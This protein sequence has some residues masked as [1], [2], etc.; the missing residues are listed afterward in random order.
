VKP[1]IAFISEHASPLAAPG[2]IDSGGQNVYVANVARRLARAGY[3]VDIFTRRS[4]ADQPRVVAW[5]DGVRVV[6][7]SAGPAAYV[8]KE[9]LLPFMDDFRDDVLAFMDRERAPYSIVHAHFWMSALVACELKRLRQIPFVVTFHALGRIRRRFQGDADGFPDERF[10]IED[11]VIAECDRVIAECP[12]ELEDLIVEYRADPAKIAVV[13]CGF[14]GQELWPMPK[15]VARKALGLPRDGRVVLHLGRMVPRKGVDTV[16]RGFARLRKKAGGDLV[17]VVAGGGGETSG[18][19]GAELDRLRDLARECGVDDA[20]QFAGRIDR[21]ML[22]YYYSAADVFV[23]VPWYEPFGITPLEAMACGTPVVGANVGGIKFTVRDAET[24]Y[25]VPPRDEAALADRLG[26]LFAHPELLHSFGRQG[27]RRVHALFTWDQVTAGLLATYEE[28]LA[29]ERSGGHERHA[30]VAVVDDAF[31]AATEAMEASR[32]ALRGGVLDAVDII[33]ACFTRGGKVLVAGN[34][35][36]AAEA[37]HFAAE[38]V[39]RF[40]AERRGLPVVS[41]NSDTAILTAWSNDY[42][43]ESVFARQVAALGSPGDVFIGFSTSGRSPN[44]VQAFEEAR[45]RGIRTIALLGGTGG[46][47]AGLADAALVVPSGDTQRIQE[48]HAV[49]V[50]VLSALVERR[51]ACPGTEPSSQK[52]RRSQTRRR[53]SEPRTP[54]ARGLTKESI[55]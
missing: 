13:P 32:V 31:A 39:G 17:L 23:T 43:F 5:E 25:L 36:S 11:R 26:H 2:G 27:I 9:E 37:Q 12:Q 29:V 40:Q 24:G 41:L 53:Q 6:H 49:L 44:V 47:C 34:G 55:R 7:V 19:E 45:K 21:D 1:K 51:I 52:H 38:L 14:D 16:I 46:Q 18:P 10:A 54:G 3:A 30:E 15:A 42:S 22:K 50:H 28:V 4:S 48:V 35:G 20:V 33:A 8:P